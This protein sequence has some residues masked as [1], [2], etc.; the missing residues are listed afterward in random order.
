MIVSVTDVLT[1]VNRAYEAMAELQYEIAD[2]SRTAGDTTI[3]DKKELKST[4]LLAYTTSLEELS[5][6]IT[7]IENRIV[8]RLYNNIKTLTK[9]IRRWD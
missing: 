8:Q 5:L 9:D 3:F 1:A 2:R 4:M 7:S 6:N